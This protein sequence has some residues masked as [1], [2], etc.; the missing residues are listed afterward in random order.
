MAANKHLPHVLV[1]PE[2]DANRQLAN[3]FRLS[4]DPSVARRLDVLSP[5]GGWTHVL[6]GFVSD[7]IFDMEK[8]H[9]RTMVLLIDFDCQNSRLD[10]AKS[11]I[12]L[13]LQ[14][15][16][17]ILGAWSNPEKLRAAGLGSYE[18]I[19]FD[20]GRGCREQINTT[21]EHDL[22]SCNAD[23]LERLRQRVRPILF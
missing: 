20:L 4:L 2:D 23:E 14:D 19:G 6:D 8:Y 17:F 18:A 10:D 13:H 1:L 7:H 11:K 21:W 3:G 15:R 12:P 16:V 22:L 5:A 9:E